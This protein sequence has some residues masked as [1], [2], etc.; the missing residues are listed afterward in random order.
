MAAKGTCSDRNKVI[1]LILD[2]IAGKRGLLGTT[3]TLEECRRPFA[4]FLTAY[5]C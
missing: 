2:S 3:Q 4:Q 1:L 5:G